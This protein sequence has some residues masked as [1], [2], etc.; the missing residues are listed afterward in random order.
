MS[1]HPDEFSAPEQASTAV[2]EGAPLAR[3]PAEFPQ[4]HLPTKQ[5]GLVIYRAKEFTPAMAKGGLA[6]YTLG[7]TY[8]AR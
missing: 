6:R 7:S 1:N 8:G 4:E 2:V 5:K 3:E